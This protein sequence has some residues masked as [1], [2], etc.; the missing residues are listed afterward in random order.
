MNEPRVGDRLPD[1][2]RPL[3]IVDLV[4]YAAATWDWYRWHY[5]A[6]A[7]ADAR[8]P[9]PLVD[10]QMLGALLARQ[11]LEW[12]G[13][14]ARI[15]RMRFRF[16]SMVFAGDVVRCESTVTAVARTPA[17]LAVS[18]AQRVMVGD[19][20]AVDDAACELEIAS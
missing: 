11:A 8:L 18:L 7:A 19:R 13:P 10:G 3:G 16:A 4:V 15:R 9:A 12:A 14:R 20:A 5:D 2:E 1:L 6:K 17:A